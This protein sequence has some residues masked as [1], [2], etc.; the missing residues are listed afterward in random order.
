MQP[1]IIPIAQEITTTNQ[2]RIDELLESFIA[3]Q[4]VKE[5]SKGLYKRTIKQY[6][7]WINAKG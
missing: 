4:D 5:S 2:T 7:K 1:D 6:F 3:D